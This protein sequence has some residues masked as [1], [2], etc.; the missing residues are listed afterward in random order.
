MTETIALDGILDRCNGNR[1]MLENILNG[2][3]GLR[4]DLDLAEQIIGGEL[5][6]AEIYRRVTSGSGIP[7]SHCSKHYPRHEGKMKRS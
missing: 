2:R 7:K 4:I 5:N 6:K 1:G 3:P